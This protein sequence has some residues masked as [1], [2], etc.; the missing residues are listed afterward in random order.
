L[1]RLVLQGDQKLTILTDT[2]EA[3]VERKRLPIHGH[4][5]ISI[6]KPIQFVVET[7]AGI[8]KRQNKK[9]VWFEENTQKKMLILA[10]IPFSHSSL[11]HFVIRVDFL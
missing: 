11:L 8:K 10:K 9:L 6:K 5:H 1:S 3:L 7:M 2:L 4:F